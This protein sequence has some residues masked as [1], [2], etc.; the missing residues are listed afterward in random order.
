MMGWPM[1]IDE[2]RQP[3]RVRRF[4]RRFRR[5]QNGAAAVEF[6]LV[7]LPFVALMVLIVE[8]GVF[9]FA[10]RHFED[11]MFN[12][13]RK[14]MTQRL[15]SATICTAFRNEIAAQLSGWF[16]PNNIVISVRE[17]SNFSSTASVNLSDPSCSFGAS[18]R[19][20]IVTATYP[21]PFAGVRTIAGGPFWGS[22]TNLSMSTA[23]R[24]E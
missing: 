16:N 13:T 8:L 19:V 15:P 3:R 7:A 9:Y 5:N 6:A 17:G 2:N 12:A 14:V 10:T 22:G 1:V 11:G 4:M 24:V 21:Y 20:V 18:Q 23:F